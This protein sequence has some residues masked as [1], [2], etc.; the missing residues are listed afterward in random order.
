MQTSER[1]SALVDGAGE[2][3]DLAAI[4]EITRD[5]AERARWARYAL[6]GDVLRAA[7]GK[8]GPG[9]DLST[10][11]RAALDAEPVFAPGTAKVVPWPA[12]PARRWPGALTGLATA[13]S[14]AVV[15]F[16]G[17]QS[18]PSPPPTALNPQ[19][20]TAPAAPVANAP[21]SALA[22]A[23]TPGNAGAASPDPDQV[24]TLSP[25]EYQRRINR[26]LVNFN[27]QR[28]QMGV[29]G[30]HPYVRVVGLESTS[31]PTP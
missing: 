19:A 7:D 21:V 23:D 24:S 14:L 29:P 9:F 28:A 2:A 4:A 8:A 16:L 11:V 10:R 31:T 26:Y 1:V 15:A 17:L 3:D 18:Q 22:L 27:E 12:G 25:E 6:M 13:A 30:V 5:P 20:A